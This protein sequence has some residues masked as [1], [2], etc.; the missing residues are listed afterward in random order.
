MQPS[1]LSQT[2]GYGGPK[3]DSAGGGFTADD[4]LSDVQSNASARSGGGSTPQHSEEHALVNIKK[5]TNS[6]LSGDNNPGEHVENG[7]G[8]GEDGSSK[9][10]TE[11]LE[12][13]NYEEAPTSKGYPTP[14]NQ[15]LLENMNLDSIP[16]VPDIPELKY[17]DVMDR[18]HM[19]V[20]QGDAQ[21]QPLSP[22]E[23]EE[24]GMG[25]HGMEYMED[26]KEEG[27]SDPMNGH[28]QGRDLSL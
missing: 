10:K 26:N 3:E 8:G 21:K 11:T 23:G 7:K 1:P 20:K 19:P 25:N 12:G 9:I 14:S 16:E 13:F 15:A 4:K 24:G 18:R 5:E 27:Y 22:Q 6:E 17:E 2:G 28:M